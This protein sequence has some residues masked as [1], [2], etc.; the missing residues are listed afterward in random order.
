MFDILILYKS[1]LFKDLL[2]MLV[3]KVIKKKKLQ[4]DSNERVIIFSPIILKL[5]IKIR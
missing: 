3:Y 2:K 5:F 4:S 1:T